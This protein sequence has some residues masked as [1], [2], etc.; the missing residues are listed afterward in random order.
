LIGKAMDAVSKK[1]VRERRTAEAQLQRERKQQDRERAEQRKRE[2]SQAMRTLSGS[3]R[4]RAAFAR[5]SRESQ[6]RNERARLTARQ[7]DVALQDRH[8]E[9]E[10]DRGMGSRHRTDRI[11]R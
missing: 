3:Q 2:I 1:R 7:R 5:K 9:F 6:F 8:Q 4:E 10:K 11:A